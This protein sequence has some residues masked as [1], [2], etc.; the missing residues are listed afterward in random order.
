MINLSVDYVSPSCLTKT[1]QWTYSDSFYTL[2]VI[3]LIPFVLVALFGLISVWWAKYVGHSNILGFRLGFMCTTP[4]Q[5]WNYKLRLVAAALPFLG[6]V[7]N[8]ICIQAF[9]IFS[10][11]Q[12]RSGIK[13]M[14]AAP[15]ITCFESPEHRTLVAISI[16]AL[17]FYVFGIPALTLS[18]IAYA[19][20]KDLLR[21]PDWLLSVGIV[22]TWFSESVTQYHLPLIGVL[23]D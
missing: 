17:I 16:L 4:K 15:G 20:K 9:N 14:T 13:V 3:P 22:Y 8:N 1:G 10:C 19:N 2:L 21:D 11:Q 23:I 12:L 18:V 6:I 7:Y 5:V